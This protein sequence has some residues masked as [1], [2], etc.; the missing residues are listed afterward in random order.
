MT[1]L[2]TSFESNSQSHTL[3]THTITFWRTG[4]SWQSWLITRMKSS[5]VWLV[6]MTQR[7]P[8]RR[9]LQCWLYWK[10]TED[11]KLDKNCLMNSTKELKKMS[12]KLYS[13]PNVLILQLWSF[14][15]S[16]DFSKQGEWKITISVVMMPLG[17]NITFLK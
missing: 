14:I 16:W 10:S 8:K 5:G 9:I 4:Q 13:K 17:S 7:I 1:G 12:I 15:Q 11:W 6:I 2:L 3:F